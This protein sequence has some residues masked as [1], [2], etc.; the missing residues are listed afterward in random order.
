M[1]VT[2]LGWEHCLAATKAVRSYVSP[3]FGFQQEYKVT[4]LQEYRAWIHHDYGRNP[5]KDQEEL[6]S[7][8][9]WQ[10]QRQK[11]QQLGSRSCSWLHL[12]TLPLAD[13]SVY[14]PG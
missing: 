4:L 2:E 14:T 12:P 9:A 1:T 11:E 5:F 10:E 6:Q 7:L 13:S 8:L 3:N